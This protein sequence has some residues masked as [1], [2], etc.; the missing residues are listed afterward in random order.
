MVDYQVLRLGDHR[1][2]PECMLD[3]ASGTAN[4]RRPTH[5][6]AP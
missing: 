5:G 4:P 1:G 2:G 3:G 6:V